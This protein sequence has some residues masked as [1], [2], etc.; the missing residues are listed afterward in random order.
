MKISGI[1]RFS[2][3]NYPGQICCVLFAQGCPLHCSY[4]Y[5]KSL[6]KEPLLDW[7]EIKEFLKKRKGVLDAIVFSG[8]EP[9]FQPEELLRDIYFV[10]N[11]GYNVGL[12]IT[13]LNSN[14]K[15]F[16]EIINLS[17]WIGLDFKGTKKKYKKLFN[18]E[19]KY[20]EDALDL[21]IKNKLN[22]EIRTTLSEDLLEEDLLEM[23]NFLISKDIKN[24]T[25]QP[26]MLR[27]GTF[28]TPNYS[29]DFKGINVR[30]R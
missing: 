28:S 21:I 9:L 29:L 25:L 11:L 12:H 15:N 3:V 24:W 2:V 14:H 17:D 19:F 1:N 4:C 30:I 8:G 22:Y 23:S 6:L 27:E 5:N 18:L 10:K 16:E 20:F 26:L 7:N 13:G